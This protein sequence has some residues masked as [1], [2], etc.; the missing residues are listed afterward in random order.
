MVLLLLPA[1]ELGITLKEAPIP[2]ARFSDITE[3]FT[4]ATTTEV[5]PVSV[6]WALPVAIIKSCCLSAM[7]AQP[8]CK[9]ALLLLFMYLA[10]ADCDRGRQGSGRR[11][12]GHHHQEAARGMAGLGGGRAEAAGGTIEEK[13][14]DHDGTKRELELSR[15][16]DFGDTFELRSIRI[17]YPVLW[18]SLQIWIRMRGPRTI[19]IEKWSDVSCGKIRTIF[20]NFKWPKPTRKSSDLGL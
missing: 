20:C 7:A 4:T 10:S 8:L 15:A 5:M 13:I 14:A 17:V 3:L 19:S 6:K 2:Q 12:R 1:G 11:H 18:S 9:P 16:I